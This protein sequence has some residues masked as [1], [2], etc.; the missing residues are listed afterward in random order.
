MGRSKVGRRKDILVR[1]VELAKHFIRTKSQNGWFCGSLLPPRS[2]ESIIPID[3]SHAV[4]ISNAVNPGQPTR[5]TII[6]FT[7]HFLDVI[8]GK[9]G[10]F[11]ETLLGKRNNILLQHE[12]LR[13]KFEKKPLY[14][15]LQE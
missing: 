12:L 7:S 14:E 6:N 15:I 1:F 5:D 10:R 4:R 3:G 13:V 11:R 8:E 9:E 2:R